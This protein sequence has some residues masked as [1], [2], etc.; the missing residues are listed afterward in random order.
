MPKDRSPLRIAWAGAVIPA[1]IAF[2]E[3]TRPDVQVHDAIDEV[4]IG[5]G[6][7]GCI[8]NLVA[9][10]KLEAEIVRETFRERKRFVLAASERAIEFRIVEGQKQAGVP[11]APEV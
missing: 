4:G 2:Q 8:E 5:V 11:Q 6:G 7:Q 10:I 9:A 3:V 1:V